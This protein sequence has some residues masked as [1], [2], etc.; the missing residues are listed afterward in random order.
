MP[1]LFPFFLLHS[2]IPLSWLH[3]YLFFDQNPVLSWSCKILIAPKFFLLFTLV[4]TIP[5]KVIIVRNILVEMSSPKPWRFGFIY[6]TTVRHISICY[7]CAWLMLSLTDVYI[8]IYISLCECVNLTLARLLA[9]WSYSQTQPLL[10]NLASFLM[11]W[12]RE[13]K[14]CFD[15]QFL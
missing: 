14:K 11:P 7:L 5:T 13:K 12:E 10:T 9:S 2:S 6:Y 8:Y 1:L 3:H 15:I 4:P